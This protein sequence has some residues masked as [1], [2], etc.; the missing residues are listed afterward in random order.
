MGNTSI[1][2]VPKISIFIN[3]N[4]LIVLR[5][6]QQ[7]FY[8]YFYDDKLEN[9]LTDCNI[10]Y[11][12]HYG[13]KEYSCLGKNIK[14]VIHCVFDMTEPHGDVYAGVSK[15][16][17]N[18]FGSDL[19]VPHMVG[20][21][22]SE[23]K[24]N[25]RADLGI[26][27]SATVFGYHGGT[28]AFNIE[29]VR[30]IIKTVVQQNNH[31]YFIFVNIPIFDNHSNIFFLE[32]ITTNE[33]KNKFICSCD[34]M[35]HAQKL[36]ETFGLSIAEF[37]VNNKPIITYGEWTWNDNHKKILGDKAIYY[38]EHNLYNILS[39]FDKNAYTNTELNCYKEFSPENVMKKFK[40]VF[41]D[42]Q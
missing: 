22:P 39:N 34:A 32:K 25:L 40:E 1:I 35:I 18:K 27:E 9:A 20:L 16:L 17:A 13:T 2:L 31:I 37:S 33:D 7:Y 24:D 5:K 42:S 10:L 30:D 11:Q 28:D 4:N 14:N 8:V 36:G 21:Y 6:F 41:I 23:S 26:P 3:K 38:T 12:I 29:F 15:T 19:Y